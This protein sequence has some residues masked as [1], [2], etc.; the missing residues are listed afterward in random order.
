MPSLVEAIRAGE[1][2]IPAVSLREQ[3]DAVLLHYLGA[4]DQQEI[5]WEK[6]R[7]RK[8]PVDE[9]EKRQKN[10]TVLL[11]AFDTL[12]RLALESSK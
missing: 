4:R 6:V 11:A 5:L 2:D 3:A 12:D 8:F 1:V 10:L 9:Y 7:D